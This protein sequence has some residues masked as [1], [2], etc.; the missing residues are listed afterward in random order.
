MNKILVTGGMGYI[1]SHTIIDLLDKGYSN[2]ISA[3][4]FCN[5]PRQ[6]PARIESITGKKI[7]NIDIDLCSPEAVKEMFRAHPDIIAII[8]FAALKSVPGSVAEPDR[9]HYNNLTS[10]RNILDACTGSQVRFFIFSSSCSVYGNLNTMPVNEATPLG[11]PLSPYAETKQLG[12]K[13]V[14]QAAHRHPGIRFVSLRYFNPVGAH[15]SGL[16]GEVQLRPENLVPVITATAI[17]RV[18]ETVVSGSDHP[19]RDGTCIRDY[20]HVCDIADAHVKAFEFLQNEHT[21]ENHFLFNLGSGK[22]VSVLEA[23]RAFEK[24]SGKKLNYRMGPK[25]P[26]DVDAIYSDCSLAAQ[27]LGWTPVFSIEDM[28]ATAWKWELHHAAQA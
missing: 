23:I 3:D 6:T 21:T 13:M 11:A 7:Q 10:L 24:V 25:R 19:T 14:R 18:P 4:N 27:R 1:G 12:E 2:V 16:I 22:G 17:G 28:M 15:P 8:H 20:V 9:Y 26:G 5:S